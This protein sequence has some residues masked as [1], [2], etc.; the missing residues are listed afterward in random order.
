MSSK[1]R[2]GDCVGQ[3]TGLEAGAGQEDGGLMRG[4]QAGAEHPSTH[5]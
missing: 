1:S 4:G 5:E 2:R 3:T